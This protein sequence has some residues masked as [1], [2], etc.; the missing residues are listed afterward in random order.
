MVTMD[1]DDR[2]LVSREEHYEIEQFLLHEARLLDQ[3]RW[4]DWLALLEPDIRYRMPARENRY[5][6][7]HQPPGPWGP[8]MLFDDTLGDLK[9]RVAKLK[10]GTAWHDDPPQRVSR[11][12]TNV[13]AVHGDD[14][15]ERLVWSKLLLYRNQR[16]TDTALHV[17][18]RRDV[19]RLTD[20]GPR[21]AAR[22]IW[23]DQNVTLDSNLFLFF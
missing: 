13:T 19:L 4:D 8:T 14:P 22:E 3:E 7:D 20:G 6:R 15:A 5:R 10:T 17:G 18:T 21:I 2:K 12:V 11:L 1:F 16:E 23:L 9:D